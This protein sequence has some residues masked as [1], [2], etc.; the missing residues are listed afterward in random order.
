MMSSSSSSSSSSKGKLLVLGG[1]GFLGQTV[2][3]RA[4]LE[5]YAVTSLSRRG[6]PSPEKSTDNN[7]P[8]AIDYRM[9]DA[10]KIESIS[11]ILSEGGYVGKIKS[12]A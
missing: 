9:G 8:V 11:S 6:L 10:G 2:C 7:N 12:V 3:K 5:G 4:T 1:T